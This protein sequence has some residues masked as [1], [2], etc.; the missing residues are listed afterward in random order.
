MMSSLPS[1]ETSID[2]HH[3]VP[4]LFAL[5]HK[6]A[7]RNM[8]KE[9]SNLIGMGDRILCDRMMD[10]EKENPS[11]IGGGVGIM[12]LSLSS[13]TE[14]KNIFIRFK[15]PIDMNAMDTVKVDLFCILLTPEREGATYLRNLSRMTR[16]LKDNDICTKIRSAE[17]EKSI[18]LILMNHK[19]SQTAKKM[20]A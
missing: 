19:N 11:A 9:A 3:V 15:R 6:Q 20:A 7:I 12:S 2:I 10:K 16:F 1:S 17:D 14:A 5:N 4:R 8:A 18:K 13:I